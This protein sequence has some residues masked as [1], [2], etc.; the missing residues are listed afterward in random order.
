[1]SVSSEFRVTHSGENIKIFLIVL[2]LNVQ[3]FSFSI[4]KITFGAALVV[5]VTVTTVD[6]R[7]CDR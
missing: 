6:I 1:M 3:Q 7:V 5:F 2:L 4:L